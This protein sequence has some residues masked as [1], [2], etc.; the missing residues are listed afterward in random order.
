MV[1]LQDLPESLVSASIFRPIYGS[2]IIIRSYWTWVILFV[3]I[4]LNQLLG[5]SEKVWINVRQFTSIPVQHI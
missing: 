5:V 1:N 2:L 3:L 4:V